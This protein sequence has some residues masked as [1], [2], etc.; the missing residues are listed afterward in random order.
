MSKGIDE[1]NH[2]RGEMNERIL[3]S[4]HQAYEEG[5]LDS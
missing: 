5:A 3:S 1:L 4:D 2:Y